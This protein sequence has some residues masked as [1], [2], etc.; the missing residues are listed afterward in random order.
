MKTIFYDVDTQNDFMNKTGALYVPGAEEL[1]PTLAALTK[2]ACEKGIPI[3]GSVD[4]HFG[5]DI[6]KVREGELQ[7]HGGPFP[8]HCFDGTEGQK[9]IAETKHNLATGFIADPLP[10][11]KLFLRDI[12]EGKPAEFMLIDDE[13]LGPVLRT[14]MR[15]QIRD[16]RTTGI[17]VEKQ[18]YDVATNPWFEKVLKAV[19]PERAIVYGVATDYCVKA[20]ALALK[21][22]GVP[23][24]YLVT[25]AIAGITPEGCTKALDEMVVVGVNLTTSKEVLEG[26]LT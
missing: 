25:D 19:A 17:F 1:K 2:Y 26:K 21:K 4:R 13:M 5:T 14:F 23:D 22:A 18:K 24:V 6:Y 9:K 3:F 12:T 10:G 7:R 20:G 16:G 11:E 15:E 8:D